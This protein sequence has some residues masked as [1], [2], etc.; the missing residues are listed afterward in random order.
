[1]AQPAKH[2][3]FNVGDTVAYI[4]REGETRE[5]VV[6]R[7]GHTATDKVF[8]GH[9]PGYPYLTVWGDIEMVLEIIS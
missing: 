6:T 8:Y 3:L 9:V 1:M 2:V 4:T 7:V 5:A